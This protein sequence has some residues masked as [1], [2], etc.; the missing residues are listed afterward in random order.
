ME[1]RPVCVPYRLVRGAV[2]LVY[3][4]P[5]IIG[6]ENL[7]DGPCVIVGNHAQMNGPIV[8]ELYIPGRRRVWCAAEMMNLRQVPDYAYRDFWSGK[9]RAVRWFYRLLSYAI[10]PL[11]VMVF[12]HALTIPVYR[13][14][15]IMTTFRETQKALEAG[16]RIVVFPEHNIRYN[17]ILW[18]FQSGFVDIARF[19]YRRTGQAL[20]FV[21]MYL[22]PRLKKAVI[23]SPLQYD[24]AADRDA[25][26]DRVS[27]ALMDRITRLAE[28]LPPHTVV[29]YPNMSKRDYPESLPKGAPKP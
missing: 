5:E 23:G 24:P 21:P 18:E 7:P 6:A 4:R 16:C 29:P 25:E 28:A 13:D 3:P 19:Y 9:P 26:R 2:R 10:A 8:G 12:T 20:S 11:S 1:N 22:A 15:R 17:R 27:R 14:T